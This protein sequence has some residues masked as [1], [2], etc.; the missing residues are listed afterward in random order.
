MSAAPCP[1]TPP[2]KRRPTVRLP[3][4]QPS[5]RF[6]CPED[7]SPTA[8]QAAAVETKA[9]SSKPARGPALART[10]TPGPS[11]R[12]ESEPRGVLRLAGTRRVLPTPSPRCRLPN[13]SP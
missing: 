5:I 7:D 3:G 6:L 2:R 12:Q 9:P 4:P 8:P 13:C 1:P 10:R 11:R